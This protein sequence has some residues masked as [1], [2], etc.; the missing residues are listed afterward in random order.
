MNSKDNMAVRVILASRSENCANP[1]FTFHLRYPRIIHGEL[2]THRVFARNARSSRAVPVM[3]MLREV[4]SDPFVPW[5]IGKNK[6]GMQAGEEIWGLKRLLA[7]FAWRSASKFACIFAYTMLKLGVHKQLPNRL[8]EPFSFIDTLVTSTEWE[9]FF[10][11]R[12]HGDAEPH[13]RD[14][15]LMIRQAK[16]AATIHD[17]EHGEWHLPY[18]TYEE[19]RV[20]GYNSVLLKVS[21]ARCARI[22]Y[23]PFDGNASYEKEIERYEMLVGSHPMHASPI[24]HQATPS[25][26][27]NY[28][29]VGNGNLGAGWIQYRAVVERRN[30]DRASACA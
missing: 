27:A 19:R 17:L 8:L 25:G 10:A 13:F 2:M 9:N 24:E 26:V 4:W 20:I 23:A 6:K 1:I 16:N 3:Q 7:K 28:R 15:A 12:V 5:H 29:G 14:L 11:L 22:S 18:I 21:A 30:K